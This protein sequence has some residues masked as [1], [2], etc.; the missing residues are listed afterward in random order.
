MK[1]FFSFMLAV[2]LVFSLSMTAFAAPT[3]NDGSI[4]ITDFI[5][6]KAQILGKSDITPHSAESEP[7]ATTQA[8]V[9]DIVPVAEETAEV[10]IQ[11]PMAAILPNPMKREYLF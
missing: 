11:R 5:Q 10:L 8:A 7:V 4:T 6:V 2:A 3:S 1:R 9:E